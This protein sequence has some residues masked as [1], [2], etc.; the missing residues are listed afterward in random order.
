MTLYVT[1]GSDN[2]GEYSSCPDP[3]T[4]Q[5]DQDNLQTALT[6][7]PANPEELVRLAPN[8]RSDIPKQSMSLGVQGKVGGRSEEC[9]DDR[10]AVHTRRSMRDLI[11]QFE[12][13]SSTA[14]DSPHRDFPS[15][16]PP[17]GGSSRRSGTGLAT[18][19]EVAEGSLARE[20]WRGSNRALNMEL[21]TMAVTSSSSSVSL[22]DVSADTTETFSLRGS[23][24]NPRKAKDGRLA[25]VMRSAS[26]TDL[27]TT[28]FGVSGGAARKEA[29]TD[30][31][32]AINGGVASKV[33]VSSEQ[34]GVDSGLSDAW[35][36][37]KNVGH[38]GDQANIG[39]QDT[40]ARSQEENAKRKIE[41]EVLEPEQ[42]REPTKAQTTDSSQA[43]VAG[44]PQPLRVNLKDFA[45]RKK[46]SS[47][48]GEMKYVVHRKD[49]KK[50]MQSHQTTGTRQKQP[51]GFPE[52]LTASK[53]LSLQH[54]RKSALEFRF[55]QRSS[56]RESKVDSFGCSDDSSK[57]KVTTSASNTQQRLERRASQR[58]LTPSPAVDAMPSGLITRPEIG[59]RKPTN[60][61]ER[62]QLFLNRTSRQAQDAKYKHSQHQPPESQSSQ[63]SPSG[64]VSGKRAYQPGRSEVEG[65]P[66]TSITF[67]GF[68]L[69]PSTLS[70][71]R[72][73]DGSRQALQA[74][75]K[76]AREKDQR[77]QSTLTRRDNE[78]R[79]S[80]STLSYKRDGSDLLTPSTG[81]CV[82]N[83]NTTST[84]ELEQQM[85]R[86]LAQLEEV[87]AAKGLKSRARGT[88]KGQAQ[89]HSFASGPPLKTMAKALER[90]RDTQP[91]TF[92]EVAS[93]GKMEESVNKDSKTVSLAALRANEKQ[94]G[95]QTT[96]DILLSGHDVIAGRH[97]RSLTPT[98]TSEYLHQLAFRS[99]SPWKRSSQGEHPVKESRSRSSP[100]S[101]RRNAHVG[102]TAR[103]DTSKLEEQIAVSLANHVA[104]HV[105]RR[106]SSDQYQSQLNRHKPHFTAKPRMSPSLDMHNIRG[107][108]PYGAAKQNTVTEDLLKRD[109]TSKGMADYFSSTPTTLN[110][111]R[112]GPFSSQSYQ[113][114]SSEFKPQTENLALNFTQSLKEKDAPPADYA[115]PTTMSEPFPKGANRTEMAG[116]LKV[117]QEQPSPNLEQ[118][119]PSDATKDFTRTTGQG[120]FAYADRPFQN[121]PRNIAESLLQKTTDNA[122]LGVGIRAAA[123]SK[124]THIGGWHRT[125]ALSLTNAR[126]NSPHNQHINDY[127]GSSLTGLPYECSTF[128][129]GDKY[130]QQQTQQP[131]N[132]KRIPHDQGNPA[133]LKFKPVSTSIPQTSSMKLSPDGSKR[134]SPESTKSARSRQGSAIRPVLSSDLSTQNQSLLPQR[135]R[136]RIGSSTLA[137][138]RTSSATSMPS[139]EKSKKASGTRHSAKEDQRRRKPREA[140]VDDATTVSSK[141]TSRKKTLG[142][143]SRADNSRRKSMVTPAASEVAVES[144]VEPAGAGVRPSTQVITAAGGEHSSRE[145]II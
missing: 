52:A 71:R 12:K 120:A 87:T 143:A 32:R 58:S 11:T 31:K 24:R 17:T 103:P 119:A 126:K 130:L 19:P 113:V 104:S 80:Q 30:K 22:S 37:A 90:Q 66:Q 20:A 144:E 7:I 139:K 135:S 47:N 112:A 29:D 51:G 93:T 2:Q 134:P 46:R 106:V 23:K 39:T 34:S 48:G 110:L 99:I 111:T 89:T 40:A 4:K 116:A 81:S 26:S 55:L 138:A 1:T 49:W 121:Q 44:V 15:S 25:K 60:A 62:Y 74:L 96:L 42:E 21:D 105:D 68:S 97:Q 33:L 88:E 79:R 140:S 124:S 64:F 67:P 125:A 137:L 122:F 72:R 83:A 18:T 45:A 91:K 38:G 75:L 9:G 36:P 94:R 100:A 53:S 8:A 3:S 108:N 142:S 133:A 70:P 95:G 127:V 50:W 131:T 56:S 5:P 129:T 109:E 114:F 85:D 43:Q 14:L 41:C 78:E 141:A 73:K 82:S 86:V 136:G 92:S 107:Q 57:K 123:R 61:M 77:H 59:M 101:F 63:H 102:T 54:A 10:S 98:V 132:V 6:G 35:P 76:K 128:S 28:G 117:E 115:I 69:P 84:V 16:T 145:V 65:G 27:E 13:R 118:V